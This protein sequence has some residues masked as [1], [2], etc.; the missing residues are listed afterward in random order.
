MDRGDGKVIV[1]DSSLEN[2]LRSVHFPGIMSFCTPHQRA[3]KIL[4]LVCEVGT[5]K[6]LEAKIPKTS[7]LARI[8][9]Q[10]I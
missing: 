10:I 5:R 4:K 9:Y 6:S 7:W 3:K 1:I 2:G 8:S